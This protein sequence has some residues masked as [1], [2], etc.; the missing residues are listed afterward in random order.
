MSGELSF[1]LGAIAF[2]LLPL[3]TLTRREGGPERRLKRTM[4]GIVEG[5]FALAAGAGL[6]LLLVQLLV[7]V[8]RSVFS[9]SFIWL[10]ESTLYLFAAIFLLSSGAL[11]LMEGHVRV[12]LVYGKLPERKR[13]IIDLLGLGFFV[14]PVAALIILV[15]WDYVATSWSQLE[16]SQEPSGIHAVFLLKSAIPAFAVLLI[17]AAELRIMELLGRGDAGA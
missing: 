10:Q 9:V 17:L 8:L 6:V 5:G 12:D 1:R 2:L 4:R 15:S 7:V 13:R 14:I 16:R 3:L 11:I